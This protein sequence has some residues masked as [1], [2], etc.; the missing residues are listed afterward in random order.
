MEGFRSGG[1]RNDET[2][3]AAT[4]DECCQWRAQV[5]LGEEFDVRHPLPEQVAAWL[6]EQASQLMDAAERIAGV[7]DLRD[8]SLLRRYVD[9]DDAV[10]FDYESS[11]FSE[12]EADHAAA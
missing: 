11:E 6:R 10:R 1:Y 3:L 7:D 9:G 8:L 4:D 12:V 5:T 2:G